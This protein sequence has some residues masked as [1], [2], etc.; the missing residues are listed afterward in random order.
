[1]RRR[2]RAIRPPVYGLITVPVGSFSSATLSDLT[3]SDIDTMLTLDE[4]LFIE[5]KSGIGEP[6]NCFK[7]RQAVASFANTSGGW[8]LLGVANGEIIAD[9]RSPWA[10]TGARALV[11]LVRDRLRGGIDPLPAFEC[12]VMDEH[13][14]GPVGVIRVY[15]SSDTPHVLKE[16]L[17]YVREPAGVRKLATSSLGAAGPDIVNTYKAVEIKSRAELVELAGRSQAADARASHLMMTSPNF[18]LIRRTGLAFDA[19]GRPQV[20]DHAL[21][22]VRMAPYTRSHRFRSWAA[23][24][25]AA[26]A[27]RIAAENLADMHGLSPSWVTPDPAGAA[28]MDV[29]LTQPP[30]SGTFHPLQ[31]NARVVIDGAGLTAA[32]LWLQ[33]PEPGSGVLRER[34]EPTNLAAT[35]IVPVIAAAAAVLNAGEFVGR[36]RCN[37]DLIGLPNVL[38]VEGQGDGDPGDVWVPTETDLILKAGPDDLAVAA[39]TA[40]FAYARSARLRYWT[41]V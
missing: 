35:L 10:E 37:V 16:G 34:R 36:C 2:Q 18:P 41:D 17:V 28:V 29:P 24:S 38:L 1:M 12:K 39:R 23:S 31:A 3:I 32:A 9:S 22:V 5:H 6:A 25:E 4:T 21:V 11:D 30:H 40:A 7:L 14:G 8:L 20:G 27:V 15:E 13:P 19:T 26:L 33:A